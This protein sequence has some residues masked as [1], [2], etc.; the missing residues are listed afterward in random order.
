MAAELDVSRPNIRIQ[1]ANDATKDM[2]E[3]MEVDPEVKENEEGEISDDNMEEEAVQEANNKIPTIK[4]TFTTGINIFDKK[5]QE[6]LQER[7]RRFALKPDEINSFTDENLEELRDS[8]GINPTN[9]SE[10]KFET[11]H[12]LGLGSMTPEDIVDYFS[13]YAPEGIEYLDH[14]SCNVVWLDNLSAARA[15]HYKSRVVRGMPAREPKDTF[16]KEF[17]DDVEE[18]TVDNGESILIKNKNREIELQNEIGEVIQPKKKTYPKNSVDISEI[19]VRIPPGY[20]RLGLEHP[21]TKCLLMRYGKV[22]DKIPYKSEK[23]SRYFKKVPN[24]TGISESK[25]QELRGIFERNKELDSK[26]PWGSLARNWERDA[27]FR[28][29]EPI[30]YNEKSEDEVEIV[31]VKNPKLQARLGKKKVTLPSQEETLDDELEV[32]NVRLQTERNDVPEK[33][34]AKVP[35]MKMYADEEEENQKRRKILM[36]IKKQTEEIEKKNSHMDLRNMLG[37]SNRLLLKKD[38]PVPAIDL[39]KQAD[40][41]AKLKNRSQRML[42]AVE[43]EHEE[44]PHYD[45]RHSRDVRREIMFKSDR[46]RHVIN[47]D[48]SRSPIKHRSV[49]LRHRDELESRHERERERRQARRRSLERTLHSD[50][51]YSS[52][53]R[54]HSADVKPRSKVAVVVPRRPAV[55]STIWSKVKRSES[56]QSDSS[57]SESE[58]ESSSSSSSS[59]SDSES[60]SESSSSKSS[61]R[62]IR[63]RNPDRPGFDKSRLSAKVD[64]KSPLKITTKNE[65]F[66]QKKSRRA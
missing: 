18:P 59:S 41:G 56:S 29:R 17:L 46:I 5:E 50:R 58:S 16:P 27:K 48:R 53:R 65:H 64:H 26:N 40:L 32:S 22:T 28:E 49:L 13:N 66:K 35:R 3:A 2:E 55:A 33:K 8:L 38:E 57:E 20:W 34:K 36:K 7:A 63:A 1:I 4:P 37:P 10:V 11:I 45:I 24:K 9:E 42:F 30:M 39:T 15:L 54:S 52:R 23:Y 47:R 43:R 44:I 51:M 19:T 61:E 6:K 31:A 12:L 21:K 14:D 62:R 60:G 25:K